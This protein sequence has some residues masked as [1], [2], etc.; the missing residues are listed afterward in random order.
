MTFEE[1]ILKNCSI[2]QRNLLRPAKIASNKPDTGVTI[3][4]RGAYFLIQDCAKVTL[5]YVAH[6]A[7]SSFSSPLTQLKSKFT[8]AEII[9]FVGRS[10]EEAHTRQL[11]H[12]IL[13]DI[14]SAQYKSATDIPV[15]PV[16][17]ITVEVPTHDYTIKDDEDVYG[18]Y[19]IDGDE[20]AV[21]PV[22]V[23]A[24]AEVNVDDVTAVINK[25]IEIF[26]AK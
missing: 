6:L 10:K 21:E 11:L 15:E 12:I 2:R 4:K 23:E 8:Q 1:K 3:N 5:N 9:D 14:G 22:K 19:D 24:K 20:V 16:E 13:T 17:G 26:N 25:L 18:D 7:Y